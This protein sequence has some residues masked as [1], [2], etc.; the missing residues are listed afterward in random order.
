MA[1]LEGIP[2][3][4]DQVDLFLQRGVDDEIQRP[5]EIHDPHRQPGFRVPAAVIGHVDVGVGEVQ[6]ANA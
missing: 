4:E 5:K 2:C 1:V 3:E 6:E